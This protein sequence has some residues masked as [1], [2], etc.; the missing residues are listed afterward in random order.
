MNLLLLI[1][2]TEPS[3]LET[4]S[5]ALADRAVADAEAPM[6]TMTA[7]A[8]L[9]AETCGVDTVEDHVFVSRSAVALGA[10]VATVE[11]EET[12][13]T[14]TFA[15]VGIDGALGTLQVETDASQVNLAVT[16]TAEGLKLTA[17]IELR[18]C[19]A[20]VPSAVMGGTGTWSTAEL[21]AALTLVGVA[22]SNGLAF[23]PT[24]AEVPTAG[25]VRASDEAADWIILLD[26]A[27]TLP[28]EAGKW[29]GQAS[30]T[31]WTH[32]VEVGWP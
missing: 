22:P 30:G 7:L 5:A 32:A 8:G 21:S 16:Y 19:D 10:S 31:G 1:A 26:D 9:L 28:P 15:E 25:Q 24:T 2:C 18:D 3:T 17:G 4:V 13:Q 29:T 6:R 14:W 27:A 23:N 20:D 12:T 11:R